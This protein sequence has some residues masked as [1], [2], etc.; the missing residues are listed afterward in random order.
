MQLLPFT[1]QRCPSGCLAKISF[2]VAR[3]RRTTLHSPVPSS[4][5]H[6]LHVPV[7]KLTRSSNSSFSSPTYRVARLMPLT[8]RRT[9]HF[10]TWALVQLD[11]PIDRVTRARPCHFTLPERVHLNSLVCH[12]T[13]SGRV[14]PD[15]SVR[16]ESSHTRTTHLF[17]GRIHLDLPDSATCR[18]PRLSLPS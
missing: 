10:S 13:L 6:P 9:V 17:T 14:S 18:H 16:H 11:S 12:F 3:N 5:C 7:V 2:T 4:L 1:G 8:H 15:S